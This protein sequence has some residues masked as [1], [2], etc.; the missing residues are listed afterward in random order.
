[1]FVLGG[2]I[3]YRRANL[4]LV[5]YSS[6]FIFT[7]VPNAWNTAETLGGHVAMTSSISARERRRLFWLL[8]HGGEY[9]ENLGAKSKGNLL[10]PS[11]NSALAPT[12]TL[13]L[14]L[15]MR[16]KFDV[17]ISFSWKLEFTSLSLKD[18]KIEPENDNVYTV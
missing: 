7:G 2:S 4:R 17:Q 1:M 5:S 11:I 15:G 12:A 13:I 14:T 10:K 6:L 18:P 3:I 16:S 9:S 8:R